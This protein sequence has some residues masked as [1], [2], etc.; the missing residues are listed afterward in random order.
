MQN[1][2]YR[3]HSILRTYLVSPLLFSFFLLCGILPLFGQEKKDSDVA[4]PPPTPWLKWS[5]LSSLTLRAYRLDTHYPALTYRLVNSDGDA[6]ERGWTPFFTL[7]GGLELFDRFSASYALQAG[8]TFPLGLKRGS[9][10][11][12]DF[13]ISLELARG[14]VWLGHG[15]HGSL[16]LSNNAEPFTLLKFQSETP[17]RIP[18]LGT[19][20]YVLFNGWPREFKLLGHRLTYKPIEW[21]ELGGTQ[22]VIYQQPYKFWEFFRIITAAE[23]N[24]ASFYNTDMR[25]SMDVAFN[26]SFLSE[27][28][29]PLTGGKLYAEY[30]GEDIFAFWQ[31]EDDLWVGP[32]GFELLD[33]GTLFGLLLTTASQELRIE[34]AQN[35]RNVSL[36]HDFKGQ[37]GYDRF[38]YKWY[39]GTSGWAGNPH[40]INGGAVMGH[41]MGNAADDLYFEFRQKWTSTSIA[42]SYN[43]QRRG[44]VKPEVL[45]WR[46]LR[47]EPEILSRFGVSIAHTMEPVDL[48]SVLYL[49]DYRNASLTGDPLNVVPTPRRDAREVIFGFTASIRLP[50]ILEKIDW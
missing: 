40:F 49:N 42:I 10:K 27:V 43:K 6:I 25:A 20:S 48:S 5:P 23:S 45:P 18:Y 4:S 16:Q 39:G 2:H 30:A 15:Y 8:G 19:L 34:Y 29:P 28:L 21:L 46:E 3:F 36:F 41:H 17:L 31:K 7:E 35:Y 1:T 13:G 47:E 37:F 32:F 9:V 24:V 50:H 11:W 14:S 38:T 22:T 26:L 33:T 12:K 44:L